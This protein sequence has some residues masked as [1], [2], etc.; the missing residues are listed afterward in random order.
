MCHNSLGCACD[1]YLSYASGRRSFLFANQLSKFDF[2]RHKLRHEINFDFLQYVCI[3]CSYTSLNCA[4]E[5][6]YLRYLFLLQ[7]AQYPFLQT[8]QGQQPLC[9]PK[10]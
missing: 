5:H 9:Q 6:N 8:H 1:S 4:E 10:A 3:T 7:S 2:I